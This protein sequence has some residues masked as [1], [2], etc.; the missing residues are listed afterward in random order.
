MS[1]EIVHVGSA[2]WFS[3]MVRILG[4]KR[5]ALDPRLT[6]YPRWIE[7]R[8]RACRLDAQITQARLAAC[9]ALQDPEGRL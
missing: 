9:L 3:A 1:A 7:V 4:R 5:R 6:R 2:R 8:D